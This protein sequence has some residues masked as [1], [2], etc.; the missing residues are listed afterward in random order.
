MRP[1]LLSFLLFVAP[2]FVSA[3]PLEFVYIAGQKTIEPILF[4]EINK[5]NIE[6]KDNAGLSWSYTVEWAGSTNSS[7]SSKKTTGSSS[8]GSKS[9]DKLIKYTQSNKSLF[10]KLVDDRKGEGTIK[11]H[12]IGRDN[13]GASK[14]DIPI[15]I[16]IKVIE[17]V[18][19]VTSECPEWAA[20]KVYNGF[21]MGVD[22]TSVTN[23]N[24][25]ATLRIQYSAY[26]ENAKH[27][28]L[29]GDVLQ[30]TQQE[31][32]KA[33]PD[34][35]D[36]CESEPTLVGS[37]GAFS[38]LNKEIT[39]SSLLYGPMAEFNIRKLESSDEFAKSYYA[40]MRFGLSKV[41][42]FGVGYGKAEGVP[43]HRVAFTG[44]LPLYNGKV[45]AGINLN[46]SADNDAE[47]AGE[48]PNDSINIYLITR[49]DF[50]KIFT[51]LSLD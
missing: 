45:L 51:G 37:V 17:R 30:T 2:L 15:N 9:V 8:N 39:S 22:G 38:P 21:Y 31:Q 40:G 27:L 12:A 19:E 49:V 24:E 29:Y 44:Q 1:H 43:G 26:A 23:L 35:G 46:V 6:A 41:R 25:N 42:Y 20:C 50:T 3:E 34:C 14:Q 32:T 48:S 36:D 4:S 7:V 13:T 16:S 5:K 11:I 28:H 10:I 18:V 47:E 33:D